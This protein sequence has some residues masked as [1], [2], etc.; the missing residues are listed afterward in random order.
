[1][2]KTNAKK[3][4]TALT[5]SSFVSIAI[6]ALALMSNHSASAKTELSSLNTATSTAASASAVSA[7]AQT[8]GIIMPRT[9]VYALDTDNTIFVLWPGT[10]TFVRLFRVADAPVN[11][12]LIG[13]DFRASTGNNNLLYALTDTGNIYTIGLNGANAGKATLISSMTAT[14]NFPSGYQSLFD[15]NTVVDAVRLIGSDTTN[16]AVVN[17]GGNLATTAIQTS[18]TYNPADVAAGTTPRV[19][20]GAYNNSVTGATSTIFYGIDYNRNTFITIDPATAGGSSATGGGVVR[21]IGSLV[22]PAG[23]RVIVRPTADIDI[24][25]LSNGANRLVGV[26]GR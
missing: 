6:L 8:T 12:N 3:L 4:F 13:M 16:Y 21:T 2:M 24:Y 26:S 17:T 10:T 22:T 11:G 1:M 14:P 5:F 23:G 20:A 15:F 18:L 7:A 25:T 9:A 19:A